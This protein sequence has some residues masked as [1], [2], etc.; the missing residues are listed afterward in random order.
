MVSNRYWFK[1]LPPFEGELK[2]DYSQDASGYY[3][4]TCVYWHWIS[5]TGT[6]YADETVNYVTVTDA[7][8]SAITK[9]FK[10]ET[11]LSHGIYD[12]RVTR[13][14]PDYTSSRYGATSY[15]TAVREVVKDDFQYPCSALVGVKALATDQLSGSFKFRCMEEGALIRYYDGSDWHVG[16][17]NNPAWVCYDVLTQPL[18]ADPDEVIGTDN[19]NYRCIASHTSSSDNKPITGANYDLYWQQG[20][21]QGKTW[22]TGKT[23]N[24]WNPEAL[25]Y[26]GINPS[27][28]DTET[29]KAWADWCDELVPSG[30]DTTDLIST[31]SEVIGTDGL[32]YSCILNHTSTNANKP[33]TGANWSTYW[34]QTGTGGG[35]WQE[36]KN[37][38]SNF[39]KATSSTSTTL[40]D[41]TKSWYYNIHR[42]KVLLITAGT[43]VGQR[44]LIVSNSDDTLP[45]IQNGHAIKHRF[46]IHNKTRL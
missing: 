31:A 16:F 27:R 1:S 21:D 7:K 13:L 46:K 43:G 38:K 23:Y 12:I 26:D 42:D 19:L 39:R 36:G 41:N 28:L 14:T 10:S 20:G 35:S 15:L 37:Y 5:Q 2:E 34:T 40:T 29:F 22:E 3:S 9:T 17:N 24:S 11:N 6:V 8:N 4:E 33:I 18:L 30:K 25:R 45:C 44:R 32:N